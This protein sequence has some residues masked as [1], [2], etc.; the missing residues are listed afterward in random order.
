MR[1]F[2]FVLGLIIS[3]LGSA[4]YAQKDAGQILN[5]IYGVQT[6][7]CTQVSVTTTGH[8]RSGP[9]TAGRRY[10]VYGYDGGAAAFNTGDALRCVWGN[11]SIDVTSIGGSKVGEIIYANQQRVFLVDAASLYISCISK[12]ASMKFDVCGIQ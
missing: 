10:L 3:T 12:T 5:I 1:S 11:S 4:L 9:Y 6:A 7:G 8:N 2:L